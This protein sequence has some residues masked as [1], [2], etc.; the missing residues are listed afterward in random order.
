MVPAPGA[1]A[2]GV[3]IGDN[4]EVHGNFLFMVSADLK[5]AALILSMVFPGCSDGVRKIRSLCQ[6]IPSFANPVSSRISPN[7]TK[8]K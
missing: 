4:A 3:F 7:P 8:F 5:C 2:Q 6:G 1:F